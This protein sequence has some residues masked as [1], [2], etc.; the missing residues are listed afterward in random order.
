[1]PARIFKRSKPAADRRPGGTYRGNVDA[2]GLVAPGDS[3]AVSRG[4]RYV[5]NG[6]DCAFPMAP[7]K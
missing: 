3:A 1:M 7:R 6:L 2:A 4:Y 5:I